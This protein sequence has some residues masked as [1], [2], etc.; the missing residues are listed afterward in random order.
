MANPSLLSPQIAKY[1]AATLGRDSALLGDEMLG[2]LADALI[3]L[4][5]G[6]GSTFDVRSELAEHHA[7]LFPNPCPAVAGSYP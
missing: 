1:V 2:G 3:L 5:V 7:L 4:V 6:D